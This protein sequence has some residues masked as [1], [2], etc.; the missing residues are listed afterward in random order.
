MQPVD[1]TLHW[2]T[3]RM[4]F[5]G[6]IIV[7]W[8]VVFVAFA[9]LGADWLLKPVTYPVKR[10]SFAGPFEHVN[11]KELETAALADLMGSFITA[12]LAAAKQRV[13][14]L[15]WIDRAWVSRR[16]PNAV[17]VRFS[18]QNFIA[19][20][21]DG[22]WLSD[23]GAVVLLPQRDG[24]KN[25][26]RL[27][28][29]SGIESQV[30]EFYK[31]FQPRLLTAGLSIRQLEL[32]PRRMWKLSLGNGVKLV[33]GRKGMEERIE[34]FI[35]MYPFLLKEKRRIRRVDLRYANG[36]AVTWIGGHKTFSRQR[37]AR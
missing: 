8:V 36:L 4:L 6:G 33:I 11:Q 26:P 32:T 13:E 35:H 7:F 22:A 30:L 9:L 29:P 5:S 28:G 3:P 12:D 31:K 16:W 10:I 2:N 27:L 24:P 21:G 20:W 34:R 23:R 19:R 1:S 18:E 14:A 37:T 15:P 25:V 17:H